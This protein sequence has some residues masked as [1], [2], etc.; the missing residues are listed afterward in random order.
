MELVNNSLFSICLTCGAYFIGLKISQKTKSIFANPLLI[1]IILVIGFLVI[2]GMPLTSYKEGTKAISMLLGPATM[3]L[4]ITVYRQREVMKKNFIAIL[5]GTV[6]GSLTSILS[7]IGFSKLMKVDQVI[8][9]SLIPKSVTTPIA[10]SVSEALEAIVPLTVAAVIVTGVLGSMI[11]PIIVKARKQPSEI[12]TG[13][14]LGTSAHALGS[15]K[16]VELGETQGAVAS[17]S[18]ILTGILTFVMVMIIFCII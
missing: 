15:A 9:K 5:T 4:G 18:L 13:V 7:V 10:M 3:S 14:A 12:A 11:G 2:S 17:I 6:C 1:A 8:M 16:A